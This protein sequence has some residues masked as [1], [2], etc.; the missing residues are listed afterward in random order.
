[1]LPIIILFWLSH[2]AYGQIQTPPSEQVIGT[3]AAEEPTMNIGR[4]GVVPAQ[5]RPD[6]RFSKPKTKG[7]AALHSA[8]LGAITPAAFGFRA[9]PYGIVAGI[10][11]APVGA[12]VGSV[13]GVI[14]GSSAREIKE[15][16]NILQGCAATLNFQDIMGDHLLLEAGKQSRSPFVPLGLQGPKFPYQEVTY[17]LSSYEDI[18]AVLE[19]AVSECQ[20]RRQLTVRLED[21]NPDIQ[22]MIRVDARIFSTKDGKVYAMPFF[23]S[24]SDAR[25]FTRW[26]G[27]NAQ[28][29]KEA[30]DRGLQSLAGQIIEEVSSLRV[31]FSAMYQEKTKTEER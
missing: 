6:V 31:H 20:L 24:S 3:P 1:M 30:L 22:L 9:G 13:V 15:A 7:K 14:K 25:T 29:F 16:E 26:S 2:V 27:D 10:L 5:F 12:A 11:L 8:G 18:D 17:D 23:H 19:F 4:V 21:I 28:P